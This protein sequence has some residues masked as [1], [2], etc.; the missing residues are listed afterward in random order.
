MTEP[1]LSTRAVH[2]GIRP[3]IP[4]V[5][6]M[7][8][9]IVQSTTFDLDDDTYA[10]I[11]ATG[12]ANAW[13]YTRLGNPSVSA[14]AAKLN[15]LEGAEDGLLFASGMA[16][17]SATL[18][19][20]VR[21]RQRIVAARDL[22]GDSFTLLTREL[23]EYGCE[24]SLVPIDD[25]GGWQ[26]ELASDASLLYVE[27]LSNP[28]L[29]VADLRKLA[30]L[31]HE[32]GALAIVDSTF[33]SPFNVQPLAHGF[34]LVLH[35]ATKFLN[36]H[37]D[38][39]AGAVVGQAELVERVRRRAITLGGCLD[40]H[41]AFLLERGLKTLGVRMERHNTN[42]LEVARWLDTRA[43]VDSVSYPLLESHPDY[44]LAKRLLRGGSGLVTA[45]V[46]GGDERTSH[47]LRRLRLIH[48]ATSLGGVE[49]LASAPHNTSH[50]GLSP[51]ERAT[52]GILPGTI[53]LS[54]GI[55]D[56]DDI[57]ADLQQALDGTT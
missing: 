48:E 30:D 26:R 19:A 21:P 35:S 47:L 23:A 15:A 31:A 8:T 28:M 50:L 53:R 11:S 41:A 52:V 9:P 33:A 34:D 38:L 37:S 55:E 27:A 1:G 4:G 14:A 22:Y 39:V 7:A 51:E 44:R 42:A 25:L 29:R 40:P 20:L 6:G 10:D 57:L 13:W 56:V 45:R 32:A 24:T 3:L 17:I 46:H 18:H 2:A 16:A 36:G 5:A 12:G 49:S 43:D 54:I